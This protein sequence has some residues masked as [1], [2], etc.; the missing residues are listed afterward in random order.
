MSL[1]GKKVDLPQRQTYS[2]NEDYIRWHFQEVFQG[3][4]RKR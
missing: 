4:Y 2:P 1:H 3:V